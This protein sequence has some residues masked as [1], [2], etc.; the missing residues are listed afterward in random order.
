[1]KPFKIWNCSTKGQG[2]R[3]PKISPH[4]ECLI[5]RVGEGGGGVTLTAA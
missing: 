4:G 1:M 3:Q 5:P 2:I